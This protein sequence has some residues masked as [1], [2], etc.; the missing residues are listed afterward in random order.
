MRN[1]SYDLGKPITKKSCREILQEWLDHPH[2][3][4]AA[5]A[6]LTYRQI[7]EYVSLQDPFNKISESSVA[8]YLPQ[9][10]ALKLEKPVRWVLEFREQTRRTT[11]TPGA[12]IDEH[13]LAQL[14]AYL[15]AG[16]PPKVCAAELDI[17]YNTVLKYKRIWEAEQTES[18]DTE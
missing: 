4:E 3:K 6:E 11:K 10:V 9:L 15:D 18:S 8:I 2:T 12:Q 7:S 13:R 1:G 14:K 17:S 16:V 5:W